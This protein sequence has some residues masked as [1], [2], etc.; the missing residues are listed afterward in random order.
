VFS[1]QDVWQ[2]K[3]QEA[4]KRETEQRQKMESHQRSMEKLQVW[5]VGFRVLEMAFLFRI[6]LAITFYEKSVGLKSARERASA[7]VCERERARARAV[8]VCVCMCVHVCMR[9]RV[10]ARERAYACVSGSGQAS[11]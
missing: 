7:S 2:K 8:C 1:P 11:E 9:V 6:W 3:F 5:Y 10:C 4:L